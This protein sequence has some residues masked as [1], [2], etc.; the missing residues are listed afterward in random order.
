MEPF[1]VEEFISFTLSLGE[2]MAGSPQLPH[3]EP[4]GDVD[5]FLNDVYTLFN[6]IDCNLIWSL[7]I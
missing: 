2:G 4:E 7:N 6:L 5:A 3:Q 1:N